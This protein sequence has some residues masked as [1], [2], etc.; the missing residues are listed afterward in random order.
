MSEPVALRNRTGVDETGSVV[1]TGGETPRCSAK[2]GPHHGPYSHISFMSGAQAP[3]DSPPKSQ[4][5][6][7]ASTQLTALESPP[8]LL[9]GY[10][11][12][13]VPKV[14][15]CPSWLEPLTQVHWPPLN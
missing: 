6:P 3:T 11:A 5:L 13:W 4:R 10:G 2:D 9:A 7:E 15:A 12:P 8:G 14:G 1:S